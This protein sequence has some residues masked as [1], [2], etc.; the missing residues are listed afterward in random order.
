MP[1]RGSIHGQSDAAAGF[2]GLIALGLAKDSYQGRPRG[3]G[4]Q[5]LGEVAESIIAKRRAHA[6]RATGRGT[7]QPLDGE[8]SRC[9]QQL[10]DQQR[11]E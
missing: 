3:S 11:P 2:E 10:A 8:E 9:A 6:Q 5:P 7:H 1:D 4:I